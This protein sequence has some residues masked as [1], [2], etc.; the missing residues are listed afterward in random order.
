MEELLCRIA[1]IPRAQ[2]MLYVVSLAT[3]SLGLLFKE[4]WSDLFIVGA[5]AVSLFI[6]IPL[7]RRIHEHTLSLPES[8][9][10][11]PKKPAAQ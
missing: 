3:M 5:V 9:A 7:L 6:G 1:K 2:G 4:P 8:A 10:S 11:S